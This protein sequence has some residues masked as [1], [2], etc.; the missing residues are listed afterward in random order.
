MLWNN[1]FPEMIFSSKD[2]IMP[3][4]HH[5]ASKVRILNLLR[6]LKIYQRVAVYF[7]SGKYVTV[8]HTCD[9]CF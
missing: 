8:H 7:T 3:N 1:C 2:S 4:F 9:K 6:F 5:H